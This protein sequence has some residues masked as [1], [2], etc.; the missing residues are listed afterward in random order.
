MA[1]VVAAPVAMSTQT[2][3]GTGDPSPT[4]A[5]AEPRVPV[6]EAK[7]GDRDPWTPDGKARGSG[8]QAAVAAEGSSSTVPNTGAPSASMM[9]SPTSPGSSGR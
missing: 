6:L 4:A 5:Q 8:S 1:L 3:L 9:P 7:S 2:R